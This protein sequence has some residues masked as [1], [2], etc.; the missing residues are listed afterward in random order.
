MPACLSIMNRPGASLAGFFHGAHKRE[1]TGLGFLLSPQAFAKIRNGMQNN[2]ARERS[3][4]N[5]L[6]W[7]FL[8][9]AAG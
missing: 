7:R 5:T 9:L 2:K 8:G 6:M 4:C 1:P 3:G